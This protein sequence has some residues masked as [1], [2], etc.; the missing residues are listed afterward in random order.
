MVGS[1]EANTASLKAGF[2]GGPYFTS[3]QLAVDRPFVDVENSVKQQENSIK[4][5]PSIPISDPW[6]VRTGR[7]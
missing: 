2:K 1:P 4:T 7:L 3:P 6:M 5:I